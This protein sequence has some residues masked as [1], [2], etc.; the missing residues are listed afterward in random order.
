M[1]AS[2]YASWFAHWFNDDTIRCY[3]RVA[4][5]GTLWPSLRPDEREE[6]LPAVE[7]AVCEAKTIGQGVNGNQ[8]VEAVS[9]ETL[10]NVWLACANRSTEA[11]PHGRSDACPSFLASYSADCI[12]IRR[13]G[14]ESALLA[15]ADTIVEINGWFR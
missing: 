6:L 11:M 12:A 8:L 9:L 2:K 4:S 13:L 1:G 7:R 15:V 10:A 14:G 5:W 3:L